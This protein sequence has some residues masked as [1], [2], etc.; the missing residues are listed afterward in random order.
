MMIRSTRPGVILDNNL[1]N[2]ASNRTESHL[3]AGV[4]LGLYLLYNA[5]FLIPLHF[6]ITHRLIG[7]TKDPLQWIWFFK[8][9]PYALT[10]GLNPF[11]SP[12]IWAPRGLNLTWTT[13]TPALAILCWPIT[14]IWGPFVTYNLIALTAPALGAWMAYL[15][16]RE[17]TGTFFPALFGGWLFGFS[18]YELGQLCGHVNLFVTWPVPML[19]WLA[20]RWY[21]RKLGDRGF[22]T[23]AAAAL[24]FL[25]GTSVEVFMTTILASV[26]VASLAFG[27]CRDPL[28]R[29][30]L[31]R[32]GW[33]A[34]LTITAVVVMVS[35]YLWLM[36]FGPDRPHGSIYSARMFSSA[37]ANLLVPARTTWLDGGILQLWLGPFPGDMLEQGAYIGLPLLVMWVLFCKNYRHTS[38]G[39]LLLYS[40]GILM[41][42][43]L[44]PWLTICK[45]PLPIPLPWWGLNR[46]PLVQDALPIRLTLYVSL[47]TAVMAAVWLADAPTNWRLKL[48]LAV[49]CTI[50]LLPNFSLMRLWSIDP[51]IP[52]FFVKGV[53]KHFLRR[54]ENVLVLPIIAGGKSILW[55][56]ESKF[57]F[58]IAGGYLGPPPPRMAHNPVME[59]CMSGGQ[60]P[61]LA[62]QVWPFIR[63]A[64]IGAVIIS[65]SNAGS[66]QWLL[67]CLHVHP[68]TTNGVE[69]YLIKSGVQSHSAHGATASMPRRK[70]K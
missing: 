13:C 9:F 27:V 37:L 60:T 11:I 53:Y 28:S 47:A 43:S 15:L 25:F 34:L 44:G 65:A 68:I 12:A 31:L 17:L 29:R 19:A 58:R 30:R 7:A 67:S 41:L 5:I 35:P 6:D 45:H 70:D 39:Q 56:A 63:H 48:G 40:A 22:V 52:V 42:L 8:W 33:L 20:L 62:K 1:P 61:Q 10:H 18:S 3:L 2:S 21:R 4:A 66:F 26:M 50:F 38:L 23:A 55:Q 16:C 24:L 46:I 57:Y 59:A 32:L 54:N 36:L 64:H 14:A 69:L 51:P 49:A